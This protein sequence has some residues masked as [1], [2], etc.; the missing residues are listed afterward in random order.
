MC[1]DITYVF[2]CLAARRKESKPRMG[3]YVGVGMDMGVG[4]GMV[5]NGGA[6]WPANQQAMANGDSE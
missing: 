4:V 6:K 3:G 2:L 5:S 1:R